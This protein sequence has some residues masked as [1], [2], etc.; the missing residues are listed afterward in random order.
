MC[1]RW[2]RTVARVRPRTRA[3]SLLVRPLAISRRISIS[4]TV[5]GRI[6]GS[7]RIPG[8]SGSGCGELESSGTRK[9]RSSLRARFGWITLPPAFTSRMAS[10]TF[11][12]DAPLRR[13]PEAPAFT[14][15]ITFSSSSKMVKI[16]TSTPGQRFFTSRVTSIPLMRGRPRPWVLEHHVGLLLLEEHQRRL[17]REGGAHHLDLRRVLQDL[18]LVLEHG[19]LVLDHHHLDLLSWPGG[20][21]VHLACSSPAWTVSS[22]RVPRPGAEESCKLPPTF[23]ARSRM[24]SRPKCPSRASS[25]PSVGRRN[26]GPW[27]W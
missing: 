23:V 22:M 1:S 8:G 7:S 4:R 5:S 17:A 20:R 21:G 14:A 11:S 2:V 10:I 26:P 16:S 3:A 13:Y 18:Q 27:S 9:C 25:E 12:P 24:F 19:R 6:G 15:S